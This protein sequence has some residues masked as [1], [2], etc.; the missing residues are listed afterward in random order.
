MTPPS[1]GAL[2]NI[3]YYYILLWL[4][5]YICWIIT[6]ICW[7]CEYWWKTRSNVRRSWPNVNSGGSYSV[8]RYL[9]ELQLIPAKKLYHGSW[10]QA[11]VTDCQH[12][13]VF[14]GW[15]TSPRNRW[16][17]LQPWCHVWLI[18]FRWQHKLVNTSSFHLWNIDLVR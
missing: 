12:C 3:H 14:I 16:S 18:N 11:K 4:F 5:S 1:K 6:L 7:Y 10:Y 2:S 9:Y 13:V 15:Y 8:S 17:Y